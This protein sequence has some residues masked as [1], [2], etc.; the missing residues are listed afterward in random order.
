M[1]EPVREAYKST[2][3][4]G[5]SDQPS[6]CNYWPSSAPKRWGMAFQGLGT[7]DLEE[8]RHSFHA[9]STLFLLSP[10]FALWGEGKRSYLFVEMKRDEKK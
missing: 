9:G 7:R 5:S 6:Y 10:F 3:H 1:G 2:A 8:G 4:R